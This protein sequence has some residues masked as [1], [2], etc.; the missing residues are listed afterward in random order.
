MRGNFNPLEEVED[1][2]TGST[3]DSVD[4]KKILENLERNS[5]IY[6]NSLDVVDLF[7]YSDD[8]DFDAIF[9]DGREDLIPGYAS[10]MKEIEEGLKQEEAE[11]GILHEEDLEEID[12]GVEHE[13]G[14]ELKKKKTSKG[15][16]NE[17]IP[18][19][20]NSYQTNKTY[21]KKIINIVIVIGVIVILSVV[22]F[23]FSRNKKISSL[24]DLTSSIENLY[25][26]NK[27]DEIKKS[28]S[29][30][31]LGKYYT[32]LEE[33]GSLNLDMKKELS[34]E[35]DTISFYIEDKETLEEIGSSDY[36]LNTNDYLNKVRDIEN[37]IVGYSVTGLAVTITNSLNTIQNE[38]KVYSD[39]KNEMST[40]VDYM[41]FDTKAY[42]KRVNEITHKKNKEELEGLLN[43][44][45]LEK[46]KLEKA[47]EIKNKVNKESSAMLEDLKT[48]L[49]GIGDTLKEGFSD[50]KEAFSSM[51]SK[52]S[53]DLQSE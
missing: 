32:R 29:I 14:R 49:S 53:T 24:E 3:G 17:D 35:L 9:S 13:G 47:E 25:T 12:I 38:Y 19:Y 23:S 7:N 37:S 21:L 50:I 1:I 34:N 42:Q 16:R 40:V 48:S 46:T 27:K 22:V 51:F 45:K 5:S 30:N 44:I 6:S 15:D 26:S 10:I 36:D 41:S 4:E 28:V 8:D 52:S 2:K 18:Q 11:K 20:K 43:T 39:L 33:L 31:S